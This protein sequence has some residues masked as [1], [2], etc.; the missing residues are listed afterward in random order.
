M[1][2]L[3]VGEKGNFALEVSFTKSKDPQFVSFRMWIDGLSVGDYEDLIYKRHLESQLVDLLSRKTNRE[4]KYLFELPENLVFCELLINFDCGN[5][6]PLLRTS[7]PYARGRFS[8]EYIGLS[9]FENIC[10]FLITTDDLSRLVWCHYDTRDLHDKIV[11][12]K[13]FDSVV[14]EFLSRLTNPSS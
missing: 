7:D 2:E 12:S 11:P 13:E 5:H 6:I 3:I 14:H 8:I 10:M 1:N 9:A 4:S